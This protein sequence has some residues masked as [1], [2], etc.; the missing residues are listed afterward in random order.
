MLATLRN[1]EGGPALRVRVLAVLVIL[2]MIALSAPVVIP[3]VRW[4]FGA[5]I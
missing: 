4:V 1:P 5:L 2:G 3:M